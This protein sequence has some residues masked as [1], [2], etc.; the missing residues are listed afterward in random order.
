MKATQISEPTVQKRRLEV[1]GKIFS[2]MN[3]ATGEEVGKYPLMNKD[4]IDNCIKKAKQ[5]FPWWSKSQCNI[6]SI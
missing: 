5:A 1:K 6:Q 2:I 4:D 3:P